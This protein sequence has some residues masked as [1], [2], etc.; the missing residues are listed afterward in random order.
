MATG[1]GYNP[2]RDA[3]GKFSRPDDVGQKVESDLDAAYAAGDFGEAQAIESY[4]MEKMPESE[5][6]R[7]LLEKTFG[8]AT[9]VARGRKMTPHELELKKRNAQLALKIVEI[10]AE[11]GDVTFDDA[12][13]ERARRRLAEA[14]EYAESRGNTN[15]VSKLSSAKVL[16][17]GAFQ[18]KSDKL[19]VNTDSTIRSYVAE[20]E[21][22]EGRAQIQA[23]IQA[24]IDSGEIT[25]GKYTHR[26]DSGTYTLT[27]SQGMD[28]R[29]F[30]AL[31]EKTKNRILTPR[32]T[33]SLELAREKLTPEQLKEVT[34]EQQV[35]DFVVGKR[36]EIEGLP[37]PKTE[38]LGSNS[39]EKALGGLQ[40]LSAYTQ[41]VEKSFGSKADRAAKKSQDAEIIKSAVA[42]RG[43]NTFV[44][45]RA[46]AN[47]AL[48]SNRTV[49]VKGA[50]EDQLSPAQI[51]S[52]TV[53]APSIDLA[54]AKAVLGD[55]R[56]AAIFE[57]RTAG[58]R[59][60]PKRV[61]KA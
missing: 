35:M 51:R 13:P 33:L 60:T 2:Y 19:R 38:I 16:P 47:G 54:K 18:R 20:K 21:I 61:K 15:L 17:S 49:L 25:D 56:Y 11:H 22:E 23:S 28:E 9:T 42:E 44:P 24:K 58:L 55:D 30:E 3:D 36:P 12:N 52:I 29:A 7:T 8:A 40:N 37:A 48:L 32:P 43:Q 45:G 6:G 10:R 34:T 46:Y 31:D 4:A 27:I 41:A 59:V 26:D 1:T 5:L 39:E 50:I 53:S 14:V 57:R